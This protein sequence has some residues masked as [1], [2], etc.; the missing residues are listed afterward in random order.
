MTAQFGQCCYVIAVHDVAAT[1][2]YFVDKLAFEP[3]EIDA[4][5][6]K[7]V[8]C[9]TARFDMGECVD[10]P[11]AKA[12]GDHSWIARIFV[13]GLDEYYGEIAGR[14]A[15][16]P[17]PPS[18]KPWGLREMLVVTPDGHRIMFCEVVAE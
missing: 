1:Q 15:K 9:G 14:G 2:A 13:E 4:P 8:Q 3:L 11:E 17:A 7:F 10:I 18:S 6:W 12:I 16:I 5:G